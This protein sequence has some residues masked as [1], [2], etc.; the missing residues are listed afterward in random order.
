MVGIGS[1]EQVNTLLTEE[2]ALYGDN[3]YFANP[4]I[5]F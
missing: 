1:L 4:L 5:S 2:A 3:I